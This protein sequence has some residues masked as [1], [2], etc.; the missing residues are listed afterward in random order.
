MRWRSRRVCS[1]LDLFKGDKT[2]SFT[3]EEL[4]VEA[5]WRGCQGRGGEG[6]GRQVRGMIDSSKTPQP[7]TTAFVDPPPASAVSAVVWR[8]RS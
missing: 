2:I 7:N 5:V 3:A 6:D 4:P 8:V 1:P